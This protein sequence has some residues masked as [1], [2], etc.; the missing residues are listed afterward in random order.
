M[1]VGLL[2]GGLGPSHSQGRIWPTSE[3]A[4]SAGCGFLVAGVCLLVGEAGPDARPGSLVGRARAQQVPGQGLTCYWAGH[5]C[6]LG[7]CGFL[8]AALCPL[9]GK[10][11]PEARAESVE[12]G[13]GSKGLWGWGLSTGAWSW[14]LGPQV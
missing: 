13:A 3:W 11:G 1:H 10:N 7:G 6:R 4:G 9:V 8:M 5:V 2:V 12:G 14:F